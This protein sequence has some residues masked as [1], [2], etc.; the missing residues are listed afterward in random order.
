VDNFVTK[1]LSC[2][3]GVWR[4]LALSL[5]RGHKGSH[6]D[7]GNNMVQVTATITFD[8]LADDSQL[9]TNYIY[10]RLTH[11][12]AGDAFPEYQMTVRGAEGERPR[13]S[14]VN[15]EVNA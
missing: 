5:S 1:Y 3:A 10:Q 2:R 13:T 11:T 14:P 15:R 9:A 4:A 12:L 8:V 7:G 6:L